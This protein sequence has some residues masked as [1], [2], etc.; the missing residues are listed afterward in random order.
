M[1]E[2]LKKEPVRRAIRTFVQA[3]AGYI[4]V[5]AA[6]AELSTKSAVIGFIS[7]AIAAGLAAAMN[8]KG[9]EKNDISRIPLARLTADDVT[10]DDEGMNIRVKLDTENNSEARALYTAMQHND[11]YRKEQEK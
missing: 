1:K 11:V 6:T 9:S 4:G 2:I 10:A 5:N 7:A 8:I 3:A